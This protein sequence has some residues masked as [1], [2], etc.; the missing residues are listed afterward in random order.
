MKGVGKNHFVG[1]D[2]T[3][4]S[5]QLEHKKSLS[6]KIIVGTIF[7]KILDAGLLFV[8]VGFCRLLSY[9]LHSWF[10]KI[11]YLHMFLFFLGASLIVGLVQI[12]V[13]IKF[14]EHE[15]Y[16]PYEPTSTTIK[17]LL[18][19]LRLLAPFLTIGI[20]SNIL[21]YVE[22]SYAES[23]K[24]IV[25]ISSFLLMQVLL[26]GRKS[27]LGIILW[28]IFCVIK[29]ILSAIISLFFT[30][31]DAIIAF[32]DL[33]GIHLFTALVEIVLTIGSTAAV[34]YIIKLYR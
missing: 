22:Y 27:L 17:I 1:E 31:E 12:I 3:V 20:G 29:K 34:S 21:A 28:G 23:A 13:K 25:V 4:K 32:C 6:R 15:L 7:R 11:S 18:W 2:F 8:V 33:I 19:I 26:M 10:G 14:G 24:Y 9:D 5:F 30:I 16:E